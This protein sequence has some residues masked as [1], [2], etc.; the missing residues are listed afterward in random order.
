MGKNNPK[1]EW[2]YRERLPPKHVLHFVRCSILL[3]SPL[4]RPFAIL[5]TS[6]NGARKITVASIVNM[7]SINTIGTMIT[8]ARI[9]AFTSCPSTK[10]KTAPRVVKKNARSSHLMDLRKNSVEKNPLLWSLPL[11]L[12]YNS[13]TKRVL[14]EAS[15]LRGNL[16]LTYLASH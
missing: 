16:Q 15:K 11:L 6:N 3:P 9:W 2:G 8:T 14:G 1:L 10:N 4:T 12:S 7:K 13:N 5:N